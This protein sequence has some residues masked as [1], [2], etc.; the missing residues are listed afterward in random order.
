M[1]I[2]RL[3]AIGKFLWTAP[4]RMEKTLVI[5]RIC[6]SSC[7][8]WVSYEVTLLDCGPLRTSVQC[9]PV[10]THE[11]ILPPPPLTTNPLPSKVYQLTYTKGLSENLLLTF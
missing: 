9:T 3:S 7:K 2:R 10:V 4:K 8:G 6:S 1:L 11:Q 5:C